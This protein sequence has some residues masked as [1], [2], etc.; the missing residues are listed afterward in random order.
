MKGYTALDNASIVG[1]T[2]GKENHVNG[3]FS[4]E[5]NGFAFSDRPEVAIWLS[6]KRDA[7]SIVEVEASGSIVCG[8]DYFE[9]RAQGLEGIYACETI[10][11]LKPF[12]RDEIVHAV[13]ESGNI[14]RAGYLMAYVKLTPEEI[15]AFLQKYGEPLRPYI[16]YYQYGNERAFYEYLER[17]DAQAKLLLEQSKRG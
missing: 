7:N 9:N 4:Y 2:I 5:S 16:E 14:M 11:P 13:L 6:Q 8:D 12:T 10:L 15:E 1:C 17:F 3:T